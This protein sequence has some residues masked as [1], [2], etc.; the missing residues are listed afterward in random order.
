[1]RIGLQHRFSC[2]VAEKSF[3]LSSVMFSI[4]TC[5][6]TMVVLIEVQFAM[7]LRKLHHLR[8]RLELQNTQRNG[9]LRSSENVS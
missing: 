2:S 4:M 6:K 3:Q 5:G 1:M 8:L 7:G 9:A